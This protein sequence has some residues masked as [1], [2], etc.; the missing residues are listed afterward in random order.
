MGI[1][2]KKCLLL[3]LRVNDISVMTNAMLILIYNYEIKKRYF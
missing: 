1:F 3:L 2:H